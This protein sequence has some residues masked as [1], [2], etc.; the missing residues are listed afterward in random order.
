[1]KTNYLP[2][3]KVLL[4]KEMESNKLAPNEKLL[5]DNNRHTYK[6]NFEGKEYEATYFATMYNF[7]SKDL[8]LFCNYG[9]VDSKEQHSFEISLKDIRKNY[10]SLHII[11]KRR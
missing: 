7:G 9:L 11:K 6:V 2:Y 5:I 10:N 1:M 3:F 8:I 4:R